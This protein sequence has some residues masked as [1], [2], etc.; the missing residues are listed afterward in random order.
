MSTHIF[1]I[2]PAFN[3]RAVCSRLTKA[4]ELVDFQRGLLG[5]YSQIGLHL[6]RG[7]SEAV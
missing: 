1:A 5:R 2:R 6:L 3:I 4:L 7:F